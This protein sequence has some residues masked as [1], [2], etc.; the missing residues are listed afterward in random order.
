MYR[1][2]ATISQKKL[3]ATILSNFPD[4]PAIIHESVS[5]VR[6][7]ITDDVTR[8]V[9]ARMTPTGRIDVSVY[10]VETD[11]CLYRGIMSKEDMHMVDRTPQSKKNVHREITTID[12]LNPGDAFCNDQGDLF[13][14]TEKPAGSTFVYGRG[15]DGEVYGFYPTEQVT[16]YADAA[17]VS[18]YYLHVHRGEAWK[19]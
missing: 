7:S 2:K 9:D 14:L 1:K 10:E 5:E 11:N 16:L 18:L 13:V 3:T 12:Q 6:V 4:R 17:T 15:I 19:K 8:R